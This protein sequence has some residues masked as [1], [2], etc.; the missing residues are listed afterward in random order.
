MIHAVQKFFE[1]TGQSWHFQVCS[2]MG[3][4]ARNISGSTLYAA[5]NLNNR[6]GSRCSAKSRCD[7]I[8]KW[9]GMDFL[10]V[11]EVSVIGCKMLVSI[12]EALCI[13]KGNDM[14]FGD[15]NVVFAGDFAQLPPVG[16]RSLYSRSISHRVSSPGVQAD[17]FG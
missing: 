6:K 9:V 4:T 5:L 16:Q 11:N 15:M 12:H 13:A 7:L 3:V 8:A 10:L 17:V 1:Q 2:F 14:P